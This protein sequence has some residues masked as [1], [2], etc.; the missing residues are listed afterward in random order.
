MKGYLENLEK[1][2]CG[3][4]NVTLALYSRVADSY[5]PEALGQSDGDERR[6]HARLS[7]LPN[8]TSHNLHLIKAIYRHETSSN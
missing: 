4:P 7:V 2:N 1:V 3:Y 6:G 5:P 8:F